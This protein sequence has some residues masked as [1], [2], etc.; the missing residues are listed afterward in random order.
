MRISM[1]A[2]ILIIVLASGCPAQ[3]GPPQLG[4]GRWFTITFPEMPP[5]LFDLWNKKTDPT[6]MTV[7][8]PHNYDPQRQHPPSAPELLTLLR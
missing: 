4:P 6:Q 2:L 1:S 5:T 8:L 7:F 3:P